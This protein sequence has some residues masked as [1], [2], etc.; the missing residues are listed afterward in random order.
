MEPLCLAADSRHRPALTELAFELTQKAAGFRRS[1]PPGLMAPLATLVRSMNCYYSN[2][3]EGHNTHPVDIERALNGNYSDDS[4]KRNLQLEAR[5]HIAVQ[6]WIDEGGLGGRATSA[7]GIR[8][9]H[10]RL[11]E[12]LPEDLL[13]VTE[14]GTGE[15]VRVTP[16]ALRTRDVQVGRLVSI[17][18]GAVPRFLERFERIYGSLNKPEGLLATAAAHHRLLWIHPFLD[19]NGR[20]AR[21]MSHASLLS[22]L[23]TGGLWSIA[24]GLA[25]QVQQYRRLLA[26]CDL[27]R[28]NALDRRGNLS[29]KAL[30]AFTRFFL[31]ICLDQVRFM[32][33]LMEPGR[34]RTRMLMWAEEEVRVGA[35]P[36]KAGVLLE[37]LLQR[38]ELP[39]GD[40]ARLTG[41][42]ERT[43][44]R[45]V[46][47]L[48]QAGV[49]T[50]ESTRAPLRL[51]FPAALAARWLPGL[52]PEQTD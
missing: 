52:F 17:S 9:I 26:E 33:N 41:D 29:E 15:S 45:A 44:R 19:G 37:A 50:A 43:A 51:A 10:R 47:A 13:V 38:G 12:L 31:E 8:E 28:R 30:A 2:F 40:A 11:C 21:L 35:L 18:P 7:D 1:L 32:D 4:G 20:V 6:G 36:P 14:P 39:R 46:A 5:A 27:T 25:R 34:L 22:M 23:D 42:S 3:I 24:R 48:L 16:G 49:A